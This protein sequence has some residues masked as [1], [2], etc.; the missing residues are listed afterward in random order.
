MGPGVRRG[1]VE[2]SPITHLDL[3]P[4]FCDALGLEIPPQFRGVSLMG[5][6]RGEANALRHD[7]V[8]SEF[9]ANGM[10]A[11]F[12]ALRS[13]RYKFVECVGERPM[14]FDL[15]EDPQELHDLI[16]ERPDAPE[17]SAMVKDFRKRLSAICSPEAV[18]ARAKADQRAARKQLEDSGLLP[19]ELERRQFRAGHRAVDATARYHPR[20]R[21]G[22]V[23][24]VGLP[25]P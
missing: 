12:F 17:V 3:F 9:H 20:V 2:T 6:L 8:M 7:V 18:D 10:P 1:A 23:T 21:Q 24:R 4:T 14:L 16:L 11:G 13:E 15:Q 19:L 22:A 5:Q 25:Q